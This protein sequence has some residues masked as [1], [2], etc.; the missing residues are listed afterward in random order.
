MRFGLGFK[1]YGLRIRVNVYLGFK[2]LGL[3]V[4]VCGLVLGFG[5]EVWGFGL[6]FIV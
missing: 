6:G 3:E 1:G 2:V 5:V 4:Q